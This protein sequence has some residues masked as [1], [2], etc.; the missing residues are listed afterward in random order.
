[1][2]Q[3]LKGFFFLNNIKSILEILV[4]TNEVLKV[5][6]CDSIKI[7]YAYQTLSEHDK[8]ERFVTLDSDHCADRLG[9]FLNFSASSLIF[10]WERVSMHL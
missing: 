1:M 10:A 5:E 7:H 4:E 3:D 6:T 9:F 2:Q 8:N